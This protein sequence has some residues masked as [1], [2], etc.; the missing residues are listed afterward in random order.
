MQISTPENVILSE[1]DKE[2]IERI[3]AQWTLNE[4]EVSA[5]KQASYLLKDQI[6]Q[7]QKDLEYV[8]SELDRVNAELVSKNQELK[9]VRDEASSLAIES[10]R[11]AKEMSDSKAQIE[12]EKLKMDSIVSNIKKKEA[13]LSIRETT[14]SQKEILLDISKQEHQ[15]RLDKLSSFLEEMN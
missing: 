4:Q 1:S 5:L 10:T 15:K 9:A 14:V 12:N 7:G 13:D 11:V 8:K 2:R 6:Q 3:R